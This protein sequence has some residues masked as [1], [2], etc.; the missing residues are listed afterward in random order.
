MIFKIYKSE[1]FQLFI[2]KTKIQIRNDKKY[3]KIDGF[4]YFYKVNFTI[5]FHKKYY[6]NCRMLVGKLVRC[7]KGKIN[8]WEKFQFQCKNAKLSDKL[9]R[10]QQ[11]KENDSK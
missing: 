7:G 11:N 4:C 2:F 1:G 6:V 3:L 8:L 9:D 10:K 5:I